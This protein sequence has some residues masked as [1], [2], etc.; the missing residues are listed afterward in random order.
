MWHHFSILWRDNLT[1]DN[2]ALDSMYFGVSLLGDTLSASDW[3]S[4]HESLVEEIELDNAGDDLRAFGLSPI[5]SS[6]ASPSSE[7]SSSDL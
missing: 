5:E 1:F 4:E 7:E 2:S 3:E 6:D